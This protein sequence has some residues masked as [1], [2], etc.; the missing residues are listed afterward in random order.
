[1]EHEIL[2][3]QSFD[4][5]FERGCIIHYKITPF[6]LKNGFCDIAGFSASQ[7]AIW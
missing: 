7:E 1:L 3:H 6:T 5:L 2:H 4:I